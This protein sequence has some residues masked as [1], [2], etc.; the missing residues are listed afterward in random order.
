MKIYNILHH[1]GK[2]E[3]KWTV[4]VGSYTD[5]DAVKEFVNS[6]NL[7]PPEEIYEREFRWEAENAFRKSIKGEPQP[8]F[9]L[10]KPIFDQSMSKSPL[11]I[12][13]HASK[14][15]EYNTLKKIWKKEVLDPFIRNESEKLR[16]KVKDFL[17]DL[18][19]PKGKCSD[20]YL[21]IEVKYLLDKPEVEHLSN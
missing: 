2:Y 3:E 12:V 4:L 11:Y 19:I 13:E 16:K 7:L 15:H 10:P 14:M 17:Y 5:G 8:I 20:G 6:Y 21:T 18:E 9:P 1:G